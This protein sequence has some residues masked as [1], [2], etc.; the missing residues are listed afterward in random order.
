MTPDVGRL[1]ASN[2]VSIATRAPSES[3][4]SAARWSAT[5]SIYPTR[6]STKELGPP[7]SDERPYPRASETHNLK[8]LDERSDLLVPHA[9][10][11]PPACSSTSASPAPRSSYHSSAP[12]TSTTLTRTAS[13][14]TR[15]G[16]AHLHS[17]PMDA[18]LVA[19]IIGAAA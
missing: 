9:R 3:P 13:R 4:T 11:G 10:V 19:A 1:E 18:A 7:G 17:R 12:L 8:A 14:Q 2:A 15:H 5:A 6:S 16:G